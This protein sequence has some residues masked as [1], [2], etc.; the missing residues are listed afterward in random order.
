MA[1]MFGVT[2][3]TLH[4]YEEKRLLRPKRLGAMRVYEPRQ[5]QIMAT[6]NLC[7]EIGMPVA[8]IQELLAELAD[9]ATQSEC[10]RV[11]HAALESRKKELIA[12]ESLIRR[13]MQ[14][15]N[16]ILDDDR[17]ASREGNDYRQSGAPFLSDF[18]FHCLKLMAEGNTPAR[19]AHTTNKPLEDILTIE[20]TIIRKFGSSNRFQTVAKAVLLGMIGD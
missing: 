13:Q 16:E 4:F 18:E 3:R 2:H 9:T 5:V 15:I 17:A 8:Q 7:R 6:I 11:F 12:D 1:N 10:D 14:Q 19:I 20:A